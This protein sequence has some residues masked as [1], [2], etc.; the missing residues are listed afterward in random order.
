METEAAKKRDAEFLKR[1]P[2]LFRRRR[3]EAPSL[4]RGFLV[5]PGWD[6]VLAGLFEEL[7]NLENEGTHPIQITQ[8]KEKFGVL[9]V[10][11]DYPHRAATEAIDHASRLSATI[12]EFCGAPSA[13][14]NR[15]GW[16]TTQ[17]DDCAQRENARPL[18]DNL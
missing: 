2:R 9:R 14:R 10:Y 15:S 13:V 4:E 1:F 17:C 12:C 5:G 6:H 8:V 7:S 11:L 18:G 16:F 3:S